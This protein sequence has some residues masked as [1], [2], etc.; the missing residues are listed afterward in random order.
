MSKSITPHFVL[1]WM[2]CTLYGFS[3]SA[4]T[5]KISYLLS[6][7]EQPAFWKNI[8]DFKSK[9]IEVQGDTAT[10]IIPSEIPTDT[11]CLDLLRYF[12]QRSFLLV[13]IDSTIIKSNNDSAGK[14]LSKQFLTLGPA[15]YWVSLRVG[16]GFENENWL[17][18]AGYPEKLFSGKPLQYKAVLKLEQALLVQ[19]ENNG[20]PFASIWLDSVVVDSGGLVSAVLQVDKNR[21]FVFKSLKIRGEVKLPKAFLPNYLGIKTGS[22]YSRSRVLRLREQLNSLVFL[23]S[24][25]NPTV[26]FAGRGKAPELPKTTEDIDYGEATINLFLQKKRASR[27]DFIIG[28]LPQPTATNSKLLLTGSLSAAFQNALNL[29]ERFSA[30]LERLRPE[31][32]KMDI[33]AAVPYILG[34]TFGAE[35]RLGIFRRDSTW[36]DA[37]GE[38]GVSY[39]FVGADFVRFFWENKTS[40]LQKV[41]TLALLASH[42]LPSTL[43]F[44]QNGFGLETSFSRLDYRFNPRRGWSLTVKAVAGFNNVRRNSQ[45][46]GLR[47]PDQ[48]DFSFSSLYDSLSG[49]SAR[50]RSELRTEVFIPVFLRS[51][52]KLGLRAAGIFS[53]KP[54]FANENYRLGGNKLLRGF[55]EESIFA[56]RFIAGTMEWRLLLGQNSFLAAFID[57]GYLENLATNNRIILRPLGFGAGLNFETRA[58]IFGISAAVGRRDLGQSVDFRAT[59]FHLGYVSLF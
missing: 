47:D 26:T 48:P 8:K 20:Y 54:V 27:F 9:P 58:G 35:A 7:S 13:S 38:A 57:A 24:R 40:S 18:A 14:A 33:Q 17:T 51:T 30:E 43:D 59:K 53:E 50:Y 21:F 37:Q 41:D 2:V 55:D 11:F 23:E 56:T 22:P 28:L 34:S 52:I 36:T 3:L 19:A 5:T 15:M 32:Q 42:Q 49:R 46:E 44:R 4:Q 6:P 12:R 45:I 1:T 10:F 29:G 16:S 31:T 25:S 39:L